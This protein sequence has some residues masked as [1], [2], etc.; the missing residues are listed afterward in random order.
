MKNNTPN[1]PIFKSILNSP[2]I[3]DSDKGNLITLYNQGY[4]GKFATPS[5]LNRGFDRDE[6]CAFWLGKSARVR[7]DEKQAAQSLT[8]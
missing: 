6:A 2:F 5:D 8:L 3:D 7:E 4:S 1:N